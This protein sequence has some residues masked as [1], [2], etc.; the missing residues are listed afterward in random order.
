MTDFKNQLVLANWLEG[1]ASLTQR[2]LEV[3]RNH[4]ASQNSI[5]DSGAKSAIS[6]DTPKEQRL[7]SGINYNWRANEIIVMFQEEKL[8]ILQRDRQFKQLAAEVDSIL[9]Q[10]SNLKQ[11][12]DQLKPSVKLY[13]DCKEIIKERQTLLLLLEKTNSLL[14]KQPANAATGGELQRQDATTMLSRVFDFL[15]KNYL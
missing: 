8:R 12:C 1:P 6:Q 10:I 15:Y 7:L 14:C 11:L 3:V 13:S 4:E 2:Q 5:P 9:E